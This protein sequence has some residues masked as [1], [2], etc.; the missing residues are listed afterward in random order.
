MG[1]LYSTKMHKAEGVRF[2]LP[3]YHKSPASASSTE[4]YKYFLPNLCFFFLFMKGTIHE[5]GS[6]STSSCEDNDFP[7]DVKMIQLIHISKG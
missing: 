2:P 6:S 1:S 4:R 5:K 7:H 3:D